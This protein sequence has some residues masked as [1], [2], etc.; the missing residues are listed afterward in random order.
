[1]SILPHS[2]DEVGV[3]ENIGADSAVESFRHRH[4]ECAKLFVRD[5]C[6]SNSDLVC[7]F[8]RVSSQTSSTKKKPHKTYAWLDGT[9]QAVHCNQE[10]CKSAS[11]SG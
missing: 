4:S 1:M 5:I 7:S 9:L 11:A 10:N 3:T 6:D 2:S 8:V